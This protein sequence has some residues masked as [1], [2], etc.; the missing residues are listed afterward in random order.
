[1]VGVPARFL[2]THFLT[3]ND[4]RCLQL[5]NLSFDHFWRGPLQYR[6]APFRA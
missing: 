3:A 2:G 6:F 1:M 5:A 4:A